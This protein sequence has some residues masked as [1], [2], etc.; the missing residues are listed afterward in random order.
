MKNTFS[1]KMVLLN[2]NYEGD[3]SGAVDVGEPEYGTTYVDLEGHYWTWYT[4][5]FF[6][7]AGFYNENLELWPDGSNIGNGWTLV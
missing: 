5:E 4:E 7:V 3:Y 6:G 1:P 2:N